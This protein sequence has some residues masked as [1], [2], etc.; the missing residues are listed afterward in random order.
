[1]SLCAMLLAFPAASEEVVQLNESERAYLLARS[2]VSMCVDPDWWPFEVIDEAGQHVG[3]AADLIA[4]VARRT[5]VN[6][7]LYPTNSWDDSL[8][9]SQAGACLTMSFLNRT[10]DREKWLIFTEPLLEDPNVFITRDEYPFISDVTAL[11]GHTLAV[12]R[13]TAMAERFARDFPYIRVIL[14]ETEPEALRMVSER[15][16]DMTLRSLI[17]AAHTIKH[18]GWF[19]LKISGEIPGYANQLRIG[20]LKSEETLRDILDKGVATVSD[21]ERVQSVDRHL[22][23]EVVSEVAPDFTMAY[24][25]GLVLAAMLLTSLF[26]MMRLK[27]ANLALAQTARSDPLTG[28]PNRSGLFEHF[29]R[30]LR[31]ARRFRRPLSVIMF[32]V[33]H[34]KRI[35]DEFGHASGDRVL[36]E[37]GQ[38]LLANLRDV[39]TVCRWG[40]EEFLVVCTETAPQ[41]ATRLA[42]RILA[43][44]RAHGFPCPCPITASAGVAALREDDSLET[45]VQRA[46]RAMYEAKRAGRDRVYTEPSSS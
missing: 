33:D 10:P 14:T 27:R 39:D 2:E 26:W 12:P 11:A 36:A 35:N 46:D 28:L 42:E 13:G 32:D 34:F 18:E 25:V 4:L 38:L 16:A 15:E 9:A 23:L 3:I 24:W 21:T 29:D 41:H 45:L 40:G 30:D 20:V 7:R 44:A 37:F 43:E 31:R 17:V 19:N 1:M 8:I 22:K 6:V 5:G